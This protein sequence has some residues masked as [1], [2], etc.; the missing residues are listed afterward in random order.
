MWLQATSAAP[1]RGTCSRPSNRQLNQAL[2]GGTRANSALRNQNS[3]ADPLALRA[4][5]LSGPV[6][7]MLGR[8]AASIDRL[9]PGP[10]DAST[11]VDEQAQTRCPACGQSNP[12]RAKFCLECGARMPV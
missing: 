2:M 11:M 7:V 12:P 4:P 10:E 9:G 5:I 8:P 3:T 1:S 6:S